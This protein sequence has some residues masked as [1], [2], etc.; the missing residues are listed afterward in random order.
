MRLLLFVLLFVVA[1]T[2]SPVCAQ[3]YRLTSW[4]GRPVPVAVSYQLFS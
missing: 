3:T 1:G 4:E 2:G